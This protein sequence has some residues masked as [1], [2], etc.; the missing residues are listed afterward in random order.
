MP[1]NFV[2]ETKKGGSPF[3]SGNGYQIFV[4]IC[5]YFY[6][7]KLPVFQADSSISPG[8]QEH[9]SNF[10]FARAPRQITSVGSVDVLIGNE[11]VQG[12]TLKRARTIGGR[13]RT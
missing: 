9:V 1:P 10:Q 7:G 13:R 11:G 8:A 12:E 4:T 5:A 3:I 6:Y 2:P